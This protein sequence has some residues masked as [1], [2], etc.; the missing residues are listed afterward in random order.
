MEEK[1][2]FRLSYENMTGTT[3]DYITG[4]IERAARTDCVDPNAEL[5]RAR[6][7][8]DH[9]YCLA[10]A[11]RAPD[12]ITDHDRERMTMMILR[13]PGAGER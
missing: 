13:A 7:A 10:L 6:T 4:C 3:E 9:W 12:E 8:L 11:G 2:Y 1:V 5:A